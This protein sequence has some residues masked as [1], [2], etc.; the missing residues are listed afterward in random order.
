MVI[1]FLF[2]RLPFLSLQ[3]IRKECNVDWAQ[4]ETNPIRNEPNWKWAMYSDTD[5]DTDTGNDDCVVDTSNA[6]CQH[7]LSR[8][9]IS[10]T[11]CCISMVLAIVGIFGS[12]AAC[13]CRCLWNKLL[14]REPLPCNPAAETAILTLLW[15]SDSLSSQMWFSPEDS[16]FHRSRYESSIFRKGG[17]YRWKPSSSSNFSIRAVRVCS[18][19]VIRQWIINR[20]IRANG[21]S[22]KSTLPPILI[23]LSEAFYTQSP[24]EDSRLFGPSPWKILRHYLWTNGFLSNPAPGESLLSGNL[25]TETRCIPEEWIFFTDTATTGGVRC[26]WKKQTSSNISDPHPVFRIISNS[27]Q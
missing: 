14:L 22:V 24:L 25:V 4:L 13:R 18:L 3:N 26:L 21:I 8:H 27:H 12:T 17:W 7:I 11:V 6:L 19:N 23:L 2:Y 20:A 16:F 15:C 9:I 10:Y 1:Q 5:T